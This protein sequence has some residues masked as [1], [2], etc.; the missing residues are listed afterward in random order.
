MGCN[1]FVKWL[2]TLKYPFFF[3]HFFIFYYCF[4]SFGIF[5]IIKNCQNFGFLTFC[6]VQG[7]N[8]DQNCV[9]S[10]SFIINLFCLKCSIYYCSFGALVI[11]AGL[12]SPSVYFWSPMGEMELNERYGAQYKRW[13]SIG[14]MELD[15]KD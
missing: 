8:L 5:W 7:K 3:L 2:R 12:F 9:L 6:V 14:E 15:E 1:F 10:V 11:H 13:R 4:E